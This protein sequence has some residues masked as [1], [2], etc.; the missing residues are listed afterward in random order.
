MKKFFNDKQ[1]IKLLFILPFR[2]F[3]DSSVILK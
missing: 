1:N 2:N 3:S